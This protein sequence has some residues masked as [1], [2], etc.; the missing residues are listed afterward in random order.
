MIAWTAA[1][2]LDSW[3]PVA[4]LPQ[5]PALQGPWPPEIVYVAREVKLAPG[6]VTL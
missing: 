1:G 2:Q 6:G 5:S 3:Q 4:T